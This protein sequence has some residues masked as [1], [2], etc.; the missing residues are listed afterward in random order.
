MQLMLVS[1]FFHP[2]TTTLLVPIRSQPRPR[3]SSHTVP[4]PLQ[5]DVGRF[6]STNGSGR[7]EQGWE[8]QGGPRK[9][10]ARAV[11]HGNG[12]RRMSCSV[13]C[14]FIFP[15]MTS[16]NPRT[17]CRRGERRKGRTTPTTAH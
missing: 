4:L 7:E 14:L 12:A 11:S 1:S 2:T 8:E 5:R 13:S 17:Q 6:D 9:W 16:D 15:H 10:E 3:A